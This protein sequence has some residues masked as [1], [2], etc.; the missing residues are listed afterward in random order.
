MDRANQRV[1]FTHDELRVVSW[2]MID[3]SDTVH[4]VRC[5]DAQHRPLPTRAGLITQDRTFTP[6][7]TAHRSRSCSTR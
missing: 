3:A 4:L 7:G 5:V 2:L 1:T 6:T